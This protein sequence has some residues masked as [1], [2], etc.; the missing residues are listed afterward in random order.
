MLA[1][2]EENL[3]F[4]ELDSKLSEFEGLIREKLIVAKYLKANNRSENGL[5]V[6]R[7]LSL[8]I[9]GA[10][11][12]IYSSAFTSFFLKF[13]IVVASLSLI[14]EAMV[15][16]FFFTFLAP[17]IPLFMVMG[18][19]SKKEEQASMQSLKDSFDEAKENFR[20]NTLNKYQSSDLNAIKQEMSSLSKKIISDCITLF[21]KLSSDP[22]EDDAPE[23]ARTNER[24]EI[25]PIITEVMT[26]CQKPYTRVK[27]EETNIY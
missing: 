7:R 24:K 18:H 25:S 12:V 5:F 23:V 10:L 16:A 27:K 1:T 13:L 20:F 2:N 22:V 6:S 21:N 14:T 17:I 8:K 19:F 3:E 11:L 26:A 4:S 9:A 15:N